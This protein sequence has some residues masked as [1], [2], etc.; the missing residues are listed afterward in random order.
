MNPQLNEYAYDIVKERVGNVHIPEMYTR[1]KWAR[2]YTEIDPKEVFGHQRR[3]Q[4]APIMRLQE[5]SRKF[6]A[7]KPILVNVYQ[8]EDLFFAENENLV[9]CGTGYTPQEALK[10]LCQHIMY[11]FEYYKN[12]DESN[13]IGDA[14]KLKELYQGLLIEEQYDADWQKNNRI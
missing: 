4:P 10:D 8:D 3:C 2:T 5:N 1:A 7:A 11:F 14:L 12:L 13:L 9:V 6:S